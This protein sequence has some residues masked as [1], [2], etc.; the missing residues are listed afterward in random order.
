MSPTI[1]TGK[2]P[3]VFPCLVIVIVKPEAWTRSI[4]ARQLAL[5]SVAGIVMRCLLVMYSDQDISSESTPHGDQRSSNDATRS[6]RASGT[7]QIIATTKYM[8]AD[9]TGTM[10]ATGIDTT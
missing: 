1:V 8:I 2:E 7:N 9:T 3:K 4:S 5:N 6:I 10:N